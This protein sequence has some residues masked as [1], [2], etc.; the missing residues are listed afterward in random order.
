MRPGS[1]SAAVTQVRI[2]AD[3]PVNWSQHPDLNRG[4]TLYED[5]A[6]KIYLIGFLFLVISPRFHR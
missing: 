5:I 3:W 4:P 6:C 2:T 1:L